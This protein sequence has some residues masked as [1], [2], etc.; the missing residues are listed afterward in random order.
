MKWRAGMG[1]RSAKATGWAVVIQTLENLTTPLPAPH[2]FHN[3]LILRNI[4]ASNFLVYKLFDLIWHIVCTVSS[5][6][7]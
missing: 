2:C 7:T 4:K 6:P 3:F 5:N 1:A